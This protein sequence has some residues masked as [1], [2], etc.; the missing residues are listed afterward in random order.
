MNKKLLSLSMTLLVSSLSISQSQVGN[1]D[2]EP[3]GSVLTEE[4]A[5][6]IRQND[7]FYGK[8][9]SAILKSK[10]GNYTNTTFTVPVTIHI[11]RTTA[12]TGGLP[13]GQLTQGMTDLNSYFSTTGIQFTQEGATNYIDSDAFYSIGSDSERNTLRNTYNVANTINIY[14]VGYVQGACGISSFSFSS[15]QGIVVDNDCMGLASNPS[16]FPHEVGHYF[17]LFHT[18][19]PAI[20]LELV[21]GSNCSISGDLMCDTPADPQLGS[22]N[23]T[24]FPT[25]SYTGSD[26]DSNGDSYVPSTSNTMSYS[27]KQCRTTFTTEQK[28]RMLATLLFNRNDELLSSPTISVDKTTA[29]KTL[30]AGSTASETVNI[31]NTTANTSLNWSVSMSSVSG[32]SAVS[33]KG[34]SEL[35]ASGGPDNFGYT[36]K[37]SNELDGPT[38]T[39][40]DISGTGTAIGNSWVGFGKDEAVYTLPIGFSFP[41]YGGYYDTVFVNSNGFLGFNF[42]GELPYTYS[43]G[44]IPA[45]DVINNIIAPFWDDLNGASGGEVYFTKTASV[46]TIQYNSWERSVGGSAKTFQVVLNSNGTITF[47]YNTMS[48]T[49]TSG[50]IGIENG[51]GNDGLELIENGS[52]VAN[53]L[54]VEFTYPLSWLSV[55]SGNGK[56]ESTSNEDVTINFDATGLANG[57][58]S[59]NVNFGS[60]DTSNPTK[61]VAVSLVVADPPPT[62]DDSDTEAVTG[63][64]TVDFVGGISGGVIAALQNDGAGDLG[65]VTITVDD[66]NSTT[67]GGVNVIDRRFTISSD[68]PVDPGGAVLVKFH[69]TQAELDAAGV[70]FADAV[71][72]DCA[73][74]PCQGG[75]P[76]KASAVAVTPPENSG[77]GKDVDDS[78]DSNPNDVVIAAWFTS[79]SPFVVGDQDDV[80]LPIELASFEG[81]QKGKGIQLNWATH[82][83]L[84]NRGFR[85]YRS[86]SSTKDFYK[87]ADFESHSELL[88]SGN[89]SNLLSYEFLDRKVEY[90]NKYFY[91]LA[92]VD[93]ANF[94]TLQE[95]IV[96]VSVDAPEDEIIEKFE[97]ELAQNFPNP[98][99]PET[100]ISYSLERESFVNLEVYNLLGQKVKSLVSVKQKAGKHSA[101][102]DGT[103]ES[104]KVVSSGIYYYKI[105]AGNFTENRKM[106]FLK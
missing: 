105:Q 8:D 99:N 15:T 79:F 97:Y 44:S 37:D 77:I 72:F 96:E 50:T 78:D 29:S 81:V 49:N 48:G 22:G 85:I 51:A 103:D 73:F 42:H 36:Y 75:Y 66:G 94:E 70:T 63:D 25:C 80:P 62:V 7:P 47:Y 86:E 45:N 31:S 89:S 102:W 23:V 43:N 5:N 3:C 16:T 27:L 59:A 104:G 92:D 61:T 55:S 90:G 93:I 40:N 19:E 84:N 74:T 35:S 67:Y 64:G 24:S 4:D 41:F 30:S 11:V 39:W 32:P 21:D 10:Y 6:W 101:T 58:Y 88:G 68:N 12:G 82:S 91:Q 1:F 38:F 56:I 83:E 87:I 106:V 20:G 100:S 71:P 2:L 69:V 28:N 53:S 76:T 9:I 33:N 34:N 95:K 54:A 98:F 46:L 52:Y 60:N 26:T 17:D 57:T 14:F 13:S 18:H 65:N